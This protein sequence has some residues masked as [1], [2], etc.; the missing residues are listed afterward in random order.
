MART[1]CPH[2][3][4]SME[5]LVASRRPPCSPRSPGK[6]TN[7]KRGRLPSFCLYY[8]IAWLKIN[9]VPTRCRL[10]ACALS[11]RPVAMSALSS[12]Q[13]SPAHRRLDSHA[14][15]TVAPG[16][17]LCAFARLVDNLLIGV[18]I[19]V[20]QPCH[21]VRAEQR[22]CLPPARWCGPPVRGFRACPR[23]GRS[24]ARRCRAPRPAPVRNLYE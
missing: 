7:R 4:P 23:S 20:C 19:G 5:Q 22:A 2:R 9:P 17:I 16:A 13:P 3:S 18:I 1:P 8:N 12:A 10:T 15:I 24:V 6:Q 14:W 21:V 11:E